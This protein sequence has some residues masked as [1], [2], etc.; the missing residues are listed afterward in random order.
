MVSRNPVGWANRLLEVGLVLLVGYT[1][2]QLIRA[3]V[4]ER[5]R[6]PSPSM[7]PTLH[8]E[9]ALGDLV[10]VNKTGWWAASPEPFDLVVFRSATPGKHHIVKRVAA[11]GKCDVRLVRGDLWV[12]DQAGE[13]QRIQKD[14]LLYQDL[15]IDLF[16]HGTGPCQQTL[17]DF[18]YLPPTA[19]SVSPMGVVE[20]GPARP[21]VSQIVTDLQPN[22]RRPEGAGMTTFVP[23]FIATHKGLD[24][25]FLNPVGKRYWEGRN[26]YADVGIEMQVTPSPGVD[27]LVFLHEYR[28]HDVAVIWE[29]SGELRTVVDGVV[30]ESVANHLF[31]DGTMDLAFGH[32]DGRIFLTRNDEVVLL[33]DVTMPSHRKALRANGL[34]FGFCGT[35]KVSIPQLTVFRDLAATPVGGSFGQGDGIYHVPVGHMFL[36]GDNAHDSQD[37]R[38]TLGTVSVDRLV[39]QLIGILSPWARARPFE[40]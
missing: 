27:A 14:P 3:H 2:C 28:D 8:G 17:E 37:S 22:F 35:G 16:R 9:A 20:L 5:Y 19:S 4:C 12:S 29:R 38:T 40:R 1:V 13:L 24:D 21:R 30:G 36:L 33:Q 32:L 15:R 18:A 23:G 39:G 34:Q 11:I 7:E 26:Y 31:S 25:S 6:I 10:L